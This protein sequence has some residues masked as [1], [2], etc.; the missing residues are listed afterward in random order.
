MNVKNLFFVSFL[1]PMFLLAQQFSTLSGKIVSDG[2]AINGAH[3]SVENAKHIKTASDKNGN[4]NIEIKPGIYVIV[5]HANGYATTKEK[6]NLKSNQTIQI[7][8]QKS[9]DEYQLSEALVVKKTAIEQVKE[10]PFNVVALDAKSSYNT[11]QDLAKLLDKASGIKIRESGGVGSDLAISLNG[12]TG[13]HVKIFMDGVPMQG[14]GSSFQL[15][16]IPV[17]IADRIEIYKG[18]V[19]IEFGSDA[20]GG[21]INIVTSKNRNSFLDASYSYGSFNTHKSNINAGYTSKSGFTAQLNAYQYYSDNNYKVKTTVLNLQTGNRPDEERWVTRFNDGYH[22]EVVTFKTGFVKKSWADQLLVGF[23]YGQEYNEVQ[24]SNLM[25]Y[26]FGEKNSRGKSYLTS[27]NYEKRNLFTK[28]L[29]VKFNANYNVTDARNYDTINRQ[30]NWLGEYITSN[31]KGEYGNFSLAKY[32]N[33]NYSLS[34]NVGYQI[35]KKHAISI[36]DVFTGYNRVNKDAAAVAEPG[37]VLDT[38]AR[39]NTKNVL[40]ISYRFTPNNK[41]NFN[42]FLKQ[43]NLNVTGP[44]NVS[45]VTNKTEYAKQNKQYSTTGYGIAGTYNLNSIQFKASVEKAYRLPTDNELFGDE[46]TE[47]GNSNLKAEESFNYNLGA[48]FN[49]ELNKNNTFYVDVNVYYRDTKDFI[50]RLV[51][52]RYGGG[53]S[54]NFGKVTNMGIDAEVRYFY[55]NKFAIGGNVTYQNLRNKE[56]YESATSQ[57]LSVTYNNRMPNIPYF[58]G[59][60]DVTYYFHDL[61][62]KGNTLLLGYTFNYVGKFYQQ[63]ENL[64]DR[65]T[66][67][68]LPAQMWNDFLVTYSMNNGKYNITLEAKNI[69][70]ELLF[71]NFSLQKPGRSFYVKF[72]YFISK[73][74]K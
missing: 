16:N 45:K 42:A 4:F 14:F 26:V 1:M 17:G 8:L 19:P 61:G 67:N 69:N 56:K 25:K 47:V 15:N 22:N 50:R 20:L 24:H 37:S 46:V 31:S 73:R 63:F 39:T 13:N 53:S 57:Q 9:N 72:R 18:V 10:S 30:Y 70:N 62:K 36:N 41:W 32:Q 59:N 28:G 68:L 54:V 60:A 71:D 2:K 64:G 35:T 3:V 55:K 27:L 7:S 43:Y 40:G 29:N 49:K 11:T 23:T 65:N 44:I 38:I 5:V 33:K 58:F 74:K 6:V 66:K 34:G 51:D 48:V 21:V 52:V 12:F